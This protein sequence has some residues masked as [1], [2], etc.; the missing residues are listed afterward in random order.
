MTLAGF[1][2]EKEETDHVSDQILRLLVDQQEWWK[3]ETQRWEKEREM[4]MTERQRWEAEKT[5]MKNSIN[6][7]K[8]KVRSLETASSALVYTSTQP[9]ND[10]GAVPIATEKTKVKSKHNDAVPIAAGKAKVKAMETASAVPPSPQIDASQQ[11]ESDEDVLSIATRSDDTGTWEPV[12]HQLSQQLTEA[13]AR[14]EAL[15]TVTQN[16]EQAIMEARGSVY[17][18]WGRSVCPNSEAVVYSGFSLRGDF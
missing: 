11:H 14:L 12:V 3:A 9:E 18:R 8:V 15:E 6:E 17:V 4:W 16:Q 5:E 1:S 7:L 2:T 13:S 10:D